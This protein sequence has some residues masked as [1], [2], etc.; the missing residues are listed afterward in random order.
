MFLEVEEQMDFFWMSRHTLVVFLNREKTSERTLKV[1]R[2]CLLV[3][4]FYGVYLNSIG[5]V[6][7]LM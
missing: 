5:D 6:I 1:W 3:E 4:N 2:P 7:K